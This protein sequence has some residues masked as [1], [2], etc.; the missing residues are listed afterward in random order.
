M[1]LTL[2]YKLP[3]GTD[4]VCFIHH[5][6]PEHNTVPEIS[7]DAASRSSFINPF[8]L[9]FNKYLLCSYYLGD[10]VQDTKETP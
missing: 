10:M 2:D 7:G 1:R 3:K 8:I 5:N 6:T 9:S 4:L